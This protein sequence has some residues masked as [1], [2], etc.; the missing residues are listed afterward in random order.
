MD[1][2]ILAQISAGELPGKLPSASAEFVR[3]MKELGRLTPGSSATDMFVHSHQS[4]S[5]Q[6]QPKASTNQPKAS[7][8]N[9][10]AKAIEKTQKLIERT[11]DGSGSYWGAVFSVTGDRIG[12]GF[13]GDSAKHIILKPGEERQTVDDTAKRKR[14]RYKMYIGRSQESWGFNDSGEEL[15]PEEFDVSRKGKGK[16]GSNS[17]NPSGR[18]QFVGKRPVSVRPKSRQPSWSPLSPLTPL[19]IELADPDIPPENGPAI[20]PNA[21]DETEDE[22]KN[23]W[24]VDQ[25]SQSLPDRQLKELSQEQIMYAIGRAIQAL[26]VGM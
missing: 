21:D 8:S 19:S 13:I 20:E 23:H 9:Y 16:A 18:R 25:S 7:G 14:S 15:E 24:I 10:T 2:K 6:T 4:N 1:K 11:G 5:K 3:R 26:N 22:E 12:A 17:R